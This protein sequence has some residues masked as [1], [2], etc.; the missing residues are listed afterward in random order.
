ML[1]EFLM[2]VLASFVAGVLV[3]IVARFIDKR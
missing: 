2:D 1:M 3:A